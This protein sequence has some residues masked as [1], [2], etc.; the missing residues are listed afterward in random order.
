M[1][2]QITAFFFA[3]RVAQLRP[4]RSHPAGRVV[5]QGRNHLGLNISH[6]RGLGKRCSRQLL[7]PRTSPTLLLCPSGRC[8]AS[9]SITGTRLPHP[10]VMALLD[11]PH[12]ASAFLLLENPKPA[13]VLQHNPL[14][15]GNGHRPHPAAYM[16]A[17]ATQLI[18]SAARTLS[19]L[20]LS[21]LCTRSQRRWP[22][23]ALPWG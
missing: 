2:Q 5:E 8:R 19:Q 14:Y 21:L 16:L 15:L 6:P 20:L 7:A 11:L 17:C 3:A 12:C 1:K 18:L 10:I 22:Q 23:P 9:P 4:Q 13:D